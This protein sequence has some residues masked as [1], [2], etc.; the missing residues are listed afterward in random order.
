MKKITLFII[1]LYITI[2]ASSQV[3][4]GN[5]GLLH[6]P[7][8]EMQNDKTFMFGGN[9]L[10]KHFLAPY[11]NNPNYNHTYNYF[12]NI[13]FF[14]WLEISYTC[15][16]VKGQPSN[17]WPPQTWGKFVN[18]DRH[19]SGRIRLWKEGWLNKWTPQIVIGSNDP[20]SFNN[21]GGGKINFEQKGATHNYFN[22]YF[23]S[24]TKHLEFKNIGELGVHLT[25]IY[26]RAQELN[27]DGMA[28]G[29]NYKINL[30]EL[31]SSYK[32]LNNLNLMAEYDVRFLNL[33]F[34]YALWKDYINIIC[35]WD[36]CKYFSGGIYF[37]VHLK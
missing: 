20:G 37:K 14:P 23:I 9:Y 1:C 16:L 22:R 3:L 7:T 17:Y 36:E 5:T 33:G 27:Y 10:D 11:W 31:I 30:K 34:S 25:Y 21:C 32:Y 35:S 18:Q 8:A 24:A 6:M 19:F 2:N 4:Y 15:T 29:V 13:T 26:S 28:I 12:I